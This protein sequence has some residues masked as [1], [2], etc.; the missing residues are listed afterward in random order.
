MEKQ[1]KGLNGRIIV[2]LVIAAAAIFAVTFG[3][4]S[5]TGG[6]TGTEDKMT[7]EQAEARL[8]KLVDKVQ[9]SEIEARK[10]AV[11]YTTT[12][13]QDELPDISNYPLSVEGKGTINIEIISSTEKAGSGTDGWLDEVAENFNKSNYTVNGATVSVSVRPISSGVA[14][15]YILSGKYVP[16]AFSPSNELWGLS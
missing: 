2:F 11:E 9:Y 12:D 8:E 5:L 7:Y 1:K 10:A 6:D 14:T 3:V 13:L 15:D 4:I 16:E